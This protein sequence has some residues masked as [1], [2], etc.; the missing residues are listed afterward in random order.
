MSLPK[1]SIII[2]TWNSQYFIYEAIESIMNQS[3]HDYSIF[4][5]DNDSIDG[6]QELVKKNFGEVYIIKNIKNVGY[7]KANNQ[8]M[9]LSKSDYVLV[10][11]PDI[12]LDK[13]YLSKI[14]SFADAHEKGGSFSGK[15]FKIHDTESISTE[16]DEGFYKMKKST[17]IDAAGLV[18]K[19]NRNAINRGEG[20]EDQEEFQ[21]DAKVFGAPGCLALYRKKALQDIEI[22]NEYFDENFFAYKEDVD[23]SWRLQLYG[24]ESWYVAQATASHRRGFQAYNGNILEKISQRKKI[25][26][27]LRYLSLRNQYLM[28]VKNDKVI[29]IIIHLPHIVASFLQYIFLMIILEPFLLKFFFDFPRHFF[30]YLEKRKKIFSRVN[31]PSREMRKWFQ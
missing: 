29:N 9:K 28:I 31:I 6:T 4:V 21:F 16:K 8:G 14:V 13:N 11:N 30:K 24:W 15:I 17:I 1:V 20:K 22:M 23:L 26:R 27:K 2:V 12:I 3:F 7:A 25:P 10:M 5:I 18:M 19:K